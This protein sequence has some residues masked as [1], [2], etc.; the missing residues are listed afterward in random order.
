[1]LIELAPH[2]H[3]ILHM[4]NRYRNKVAEG[5]SR[6]LLPAAR[7]ARM[8]WSTE[9]EQLAAIYVAQCE[10]TIQ[11]CMS[12]P[13]FTT[14][15]SILD[16]VEFVGV[17]RASIVPMLLEET[18]KVWFEDTRFVTRSMVQQLTGSL[19]SR[20]LRQVLL[21]MTDRNSHVGCS[22]LFFKEMLTNY[23]RLFCTFA[24]D[25]VTD[26]PVYNVS[27]P[28][29]RQCR[30]LDTTYENLCALGEKY[31]HSEKYSELRM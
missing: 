21:L 30:R 31:N 13:R 27:L 16:G 4:L 7:M 11:P 28:A 18:I 12:S 17:Y 23:F 10:T 19:K 5:Y 6:R 24:T 3:Q 26:L 22:G 29:G 9:L 15:G 1:Q 25:L 8:D 20:S 2:Q 14:I